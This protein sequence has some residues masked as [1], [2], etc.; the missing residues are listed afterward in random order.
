VSDDGAGFVE[1][2]VRPGDVVAGKFRVE[3]ILGEGGMGVVVSA[4][5][6]QLDQIYTC[7]AAMGACATP[8]VVAKTEYVSAMTNDSAML[9]WTGDGVLKVAK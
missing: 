8:T 4:H 1:A 9:Y 2:G 7:P 6:L 3:R 5:H